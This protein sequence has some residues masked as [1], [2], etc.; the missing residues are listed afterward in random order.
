MPVLTAHPGVY[1]EEVPSGVRT[2]TGVATSITAFVGR[3]LRGPTDEVGP[4]TINS[5]GDFERIFGGLW[6]FSPLS[7]AVRDFYR[8]GGSQAVIVR[9][10]HPSEEERADALDAAQ[11]VA[12]AA[13]AAGP[14][15]ADVA[16]AARTQADLPENAAEPRSS[17]ADAVASAAEAAAALPGAD[18][19][20]VQAA[21]A[22]ALSTVTPVTRARLELDTLELR[23]ANPGAWGNQLRARIDHD[24]L[25]TGNTDRFNLT[26]RDGISGRDRNIPERLSR[27]YRC[28]QSGA[29]AR[30]GVHSGASCRDSPDRTTGMQRPPTSTASCRREPILSTIPIPAKSAPRHPTDPIPESATTKAVSLSKT[31]IFAARSRRSLQ[32]PV[33]SSILVR[34]GCESGRDLAGRSVLRTA[35]RDAAHRCAAAWDSVAAANTGISGPW[36]RT[37]R[38]R[39]SSSH[40]DSA[41]SPT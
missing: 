35:P 38:T 13:A 3:T 24:V 10:F 23:A 21:A 8:N 22:A 30:T 37:A 39:P 17:A 1:I 40:A 27:P 28:S 29:R 31:G 19:A 7:F 11:D 5:F 33:H 32:S 41:E 14:G 2:I 4:V 9:L 36:E 26:V 20:S 25:P 15:P 12:D 16:T 18:A 34:R 6:E